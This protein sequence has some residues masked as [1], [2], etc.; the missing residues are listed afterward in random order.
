MAFRSKTPSRLLRELSTLSSRHKT[1]RF[2]AVDN[3]IDHAYFRTFLP[4]LVRSE[5]DYD[6]FYEL[7]SNLSRDDLRLL[8]RAG[9]R[10]VQP[11]IESLSTNVLRLMRKGVSALQ[12]VNTLRWCG[13]YGIS[14]YYNLL[15]GFPGETSDDYE[16]ELGL[17]RQLLHL[18]PP[19]GWGRVWLERF[20][21]IITDRQAFPADF[22]RPTPSYAFVYPKRVALER[23]AYFFDHTMDGTLPDEAHARTADFLFTWKRA[24]SSATRPTLTYRRSGDF[25]QID[26][27]RP[28]RSGSYD[29][30]GALARLYHAASERP[31]STKGLAERLAIDAS[32]PEIEGALDAFC[33][34]GLM[35]RDGDQF[36]SLAL[37]ATLE[38]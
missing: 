27:Q 34:R 1:F 8:V 24:W 35:A 31:I 29:F 11:G 30:E 32:G 12:N 10:R 33:E 16:S 26:D 38:R 25:L 19:V 3:I 37:P 21:P 14:V 28:N 36:L 20:S 9:V 4:E 15:W 23:V 18:T 5:L 22:V 17:M 6:L 2:E 7:K 13:Y